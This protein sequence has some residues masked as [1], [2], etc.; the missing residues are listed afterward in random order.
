MSFSDTE[1]IKNEL[2]TL[3]TTDNLKTCNISIIELLDVLAYGLDEILDMHSDIDVLDY[4]YRVMN[5]IECKI[6]ADIL[7]LDH[8]DT[9]VYK[10]TRRLLYEILL[11]I[12][13]IKV[14]VED[15]G[16]DEIRT[17][18]KNLNDEICDILEFKKFEFSD[19]EMESIYAKC[20]LNLKT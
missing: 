19:S 2:L 17:K 18:F 1:K 14:K 12:V 4:K 13:Y 16:N 5:N 20:E 10:K 8:N 15:T 3:C 6:K 11:Q 7:S 9:P